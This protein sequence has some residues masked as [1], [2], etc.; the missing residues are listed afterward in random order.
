[1]LRREF[2]TLLSGATVAWPLAARAQPAIKVWRIGLLMTIAESEPEAQARL[3]SLREGLRALGWTEG[4]NIRIDYR[5]AA[6]DP[7]RARSSA[8]ELVSLGPDV[9]LANGTAILSALR[10]ATQSIPIVFVL[11]P[12]PVGDGFVAS[13]ARPGGN[14]T[15]ITNFEFPMGGKWVEFLKEMAPH[16][17]HVALIFNPE[18]APY[19]RHFLQSVAV[20]AEATLLPVRNDSDIERALETVAGQSKSGLIIV[21]DLFTSGHRELIVALAARHRL[22]AIYPF[23]FFVAHGGLLSYG[24]DTLDLFRRSASFI[25]RILKGDKPSD[26]PVQAPTKFELVINLKTAKALGLEVPPTLLARADEVIE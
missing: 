13:L 2:I 17:S 19:A 7:E 10:Q 6:G 3:A 5:F 25:D 8:A 14:L 1:M 12:D 15:G 20:G 9:I 4:H 24:V 11:V 23:R 18:T 26:L 21:P 22:P 16:L